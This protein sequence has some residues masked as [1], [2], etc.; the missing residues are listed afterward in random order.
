MRKMV[1]RSHE[2]AR[3]ARVAARIAQRGGALAKM[4]EKVLAYNISKL[5]RTREKLSELEQRERDGA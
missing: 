1:R 3:E 2:N 4:L 5:I